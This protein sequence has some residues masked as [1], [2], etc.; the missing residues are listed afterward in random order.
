VEAWTELARTRTA[1][2]E[3]LVL[4]GRGSVFEIRCDGWELMSSRAHH[5]ESALAR[6]GCARLAGAARVLIGG[7]GMGYTLRAALDALD[8]SARVVV[9]ELLPEVVAWNRGP[10]APLA[11]RPLADGRVSVEYRDVAAVLGERRGAFDAVLLDVDNG[12]EA[13]MLAGNRGLYG[14]EGLALMRA[15]LLAGGVLA[16]WSAD[17]SAAFEARLTAAGWRWTATQVPARGG[18]DDPRHTIYLG[19]P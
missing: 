13:V 1:G 19:E 12:P 7:L 5:S 16:V 8:A 17:R 3:E 6:L 14:A 4:R 15:A 2:G 11:G 18:P 9:A 10:L